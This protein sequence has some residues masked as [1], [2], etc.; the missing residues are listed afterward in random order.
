MKCWLLGWIGDVRR[1]RGGEWAR[2]SLCVCCVSESRGIFRW[3]NIVAIVWLLGSVH[4][5]LRWHSPL[6]CL[7]V[8]ITRRV[9]IPHSG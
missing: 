4:L 7:H 6:P 1:G 9:P 8:V 5:V 3:G 2:A